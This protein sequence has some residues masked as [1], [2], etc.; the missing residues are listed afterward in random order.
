MI[1]GQNY[2]PY[3]AELIELEAVNIDEPYLWSLEEY[4]NTEVVIPN[5][6]G[7][8]AFAKVKKWKCDSIG[9]PVEDANPN[10]FLYTMAYQLEFPDGATAKYSVNVVNDNLFNHTS[11]GGWNSSIYFSRL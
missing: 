7:M 8:P 4:I 3:D 10:P 6:K 1:H 2:L 11:K 5:M 9:L